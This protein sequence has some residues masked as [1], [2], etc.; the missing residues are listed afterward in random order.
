VTSRTFEIERSNRNFPTFHHRD[1][2]HL[3]GD[4]LLEKVESKSK[5]DRGVI[6]V[7]TFRFQPAWREVCYFKRKL[8]LYN[9]RVR[10]AA[11]ASVQPPRVSA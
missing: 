11:A 8:L 4:A 3:R 10:T 9:D 2:N 7:E 5:N 6:V 1:K